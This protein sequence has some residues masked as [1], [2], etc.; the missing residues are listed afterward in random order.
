MT[1]WLTFLQQM[2]I[3]SLLSPGPVWLSPPCVCVLNAHIY[4]MYMTWH[5]NFILC[6]NCQSLYTLN[7]CYLDQCLVFLIGQEDPWGD[8]L[9]NP[10]P[11][12]YR[13]QFLTFVVDA[14]STE[15]KWSLRGNTGRRRPFKTSRAAALQPQA[16]WQ[17]TNCWELPVA[18]K[19]AWQTVVRLKSQ[20]TFYSQSF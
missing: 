1:E 16:P 9:H 3:E 15:W 14:E 4:S 10:C 12:Q 17:D 6:M 13:A 19:P 11:T 7:G 20:T 5:N 18:S 8:S 2:L